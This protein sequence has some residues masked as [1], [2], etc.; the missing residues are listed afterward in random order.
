MYDRT[1]FALSYMPLAI[2]RQTE[3]QIIEDK[4]SATYP[5]IK[6]VKAA[7]TCSAKLNGAKFIETEPLGVGAPFQKNSART[8]DYREA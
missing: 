1:F 6:I 4:K 2:T 8:S 5:K 3:K 7:I